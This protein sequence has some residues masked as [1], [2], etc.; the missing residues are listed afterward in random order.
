M[1]HFVK[2]NTE[3]ELLKQW[4]DPAVPHM[5]MC[6]QQTKL[7][8]CVIMNGQIYATYEPFEITETTTWHTINGPIVV[9]PGIYFIHPNK[10]E[11]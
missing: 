3:E 2:I 8:E 6:F 10:E 5:S 7:E 4:F 9:P 11:F 1:I